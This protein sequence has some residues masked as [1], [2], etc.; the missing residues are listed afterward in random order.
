MTEILKTIS[1]VKLSSTFL[2][3]VSLFSLL[4]IDKRVNLW[5][6]V[7]NYKFHLSYSSELF[8]E[9][10]LIDVVFNIHF[11]RLRRWIYSLRSRFAI[12]YRLIQNFVICSERAHGTCMRYGDVLW[13]M[14]VT[15]TNLGYGDFTPSNYLSRIIIS[16]LSLLG[17]FPNKC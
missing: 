14:G 6:T 15:I 2:L 3:K 8:L 1:S 13:M 16:I 7:I 17:P 11:Q 4:K 5:S 10:A 9:E 12:S